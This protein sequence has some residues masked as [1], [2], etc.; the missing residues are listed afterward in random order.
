[1]LTEGFS[2]PGQTS[3]RSLVSEVEQAFKTPSATF[4][5]LCLNN[6]IVCVK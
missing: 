2:K 5:Q 6:E 1:M 4:F 3:G